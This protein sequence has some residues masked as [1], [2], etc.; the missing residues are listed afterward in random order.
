MFTSIIIKDHLN[1]V[2]L[3]DLLIKILLFAIV[4]ID[5]KLDPCFLIKPIGQQANQRFSHPRL[6]FSTISKQ[7]I[8]LFASIGQCLYG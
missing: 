3:L 1:K 8:W 7:N 6:S 4:L 2:A 5:P